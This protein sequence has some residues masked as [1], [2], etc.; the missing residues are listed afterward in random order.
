MRDR[1]YK[2]IWGTKYMLTRHYRKWKYRGTE[3]EI[4]L[5]N[6]E[7]DPGE[8][9]NIS[10]LFPDVVKKLEYFGLQNYEKMVPPGVGQKNWVI[11]WS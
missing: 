2:L 10:R 5:Y 6:L 3:E 7:T 11:V 4:E 1:N 9:E 8:R